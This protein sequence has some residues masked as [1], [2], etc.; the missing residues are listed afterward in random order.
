MASKRVRME[1]T[2]DQWGKL[3]R[4]VFSKPMLSGE[5]RRKAAKSLI[6]LPN[7][8]AAVDVFCEGRFVG[9]L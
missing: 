9:V 7:N 3:S 5:Q 4:E 6:H 8:G 2:T 1:V